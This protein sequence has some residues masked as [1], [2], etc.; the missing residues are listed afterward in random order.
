MCGRF[1]VTLPPDA[2]RG[3]FAYEEQPNFPPRYNIAPTQPIAIVR[4]LRGESGVTRHFS[5]ARWAFLPGFVKDPKNFP[6][7]FNARCEG[8]SEKASFRNAIR[9]RRCLVPADCF[10]EWRRAGKE[11]PQPYLFKSAGGGPLALAGLW[12]TWI[13]PNGEEVDTACIVTTPANGATATIHA[14]LPAIIAPRHFTL[15]L[16]PDERATD[17]AVDLLHPPENDVLTFMAI[18]DAVNKAANDGP[19]IQHPLAAQPAMPKA[20]PTGPE[21]ASLF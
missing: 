18:G 1:A 12:E 9:R 8:L 3:L 21:Q 10:Y 14:R 20:A 15:W 13:G 7:V 17:E 11:K 19:E 4:A 2:M 6:L 16:D 5:L